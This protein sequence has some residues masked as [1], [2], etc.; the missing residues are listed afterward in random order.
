VLG[1]RDHR[2]DGLVRPA[3]VGVAPRQGDVGHHRERGI[4]GLLGPADGHRG[5]PADGERLAERGGRGHRLAQRPHRQRGVTRAGG[6]RGAPGPS[7]A[8]GIR[9]VRGDEGGLGL[10]PGPQ[11][12]VRGTGQGL[13]EQGRGL[14]RHA[15]R[16]HRHGR[17]QQPLGA[18]LGVAGEAGGPHQR[19]GLGPELPPPAGRGGRALEGQGGIFVVAHG[20]GAEVPGAALLEPVVEGLRVGPVGRP[21]FGGG[22]RG[23][24]RGARERVDER[25]LAGLE[26]H[27]AGL[28]DRLERLERE[29]GRVE[30]RAGTGQVA[31]G[32]GDGG[33]QPGGRGKLAEAGGERVLDRGADGQRHHALAPALER[34]G[35]RGPGELAQRQRVAG[36]LAEEEATVVAAQRRRAQGVEQPLRVVGRQRAER[37]LLEP[38]QPAVLAGRRPGGE[39]AGHVVGL[40]AVGGERQGRQRGL[41]EP[42]GVV[43]HQQ[44]RALLGGVGQQRE[45]RDTEGEAAAGGLTVEREGRPQRGALGQRQEVDP[46]E[47]RPAGA[48]QT[49]VVHPLDGVDAAAA[50]EAEVAGAGDGVLEQRGLPESGVAAHHERAGA[51]EPGIVER[52]LEAGHL[53]LAPEERPAGRTDS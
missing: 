24:G 33:R 1:G 17:R 43:D 35:G 48:V 14:A 22:C 15:G 10:D 11:E 7:Q 18:A 34:V 3:L 29:P 25:D 28:L 12:R 6:Q 52:V 50:Q 9:Q 45:H 39:E 8:L 30:G 5:Q 19:G 26:G 42:V 40:E 44:D 27:Q 23:V 36:G 38:G 32:G 41:V 21:A 53:G 20:G 2:V 49:G 16:L 47:Q 4:A 46:V 13:V 31:A 37:H 51:P